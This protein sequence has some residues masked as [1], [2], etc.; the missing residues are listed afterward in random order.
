MCYMNI[1]YYKSGFILIRKKVI[2]N[3]IVVSVKLIYP[4]SITQYIISN[5]NYTLSDKLTLKTLLNGY[6]RLIDK[7]N[8]Q[9]KIN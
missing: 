2:D 9:I 3:E 5:D 6:Y 7:Y 4:V 1:K 8:H